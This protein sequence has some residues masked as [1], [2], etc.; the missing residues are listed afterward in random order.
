MKCKGHPHHHIKTG[1]A[2]KTHAHFVVR[3][4][5]IFWN[6]GRW[7]P[8]AAD[9]S[10]RR[11]ASLLASQ[12][13]TQVIAYRIHKAK[14]KFESSSSPPLQTPSLLHF[15]LFYIQYHRIKGKTHTALF[16]PMLSV[17]YGQ[18]EFSFHADYNFV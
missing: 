15:P 1:D 9:N 6:C 5:I 4:I 17:S 12:A 13:G 11:D 8:D 3:Y 16:Y 14:R 7:K 18:I 2:I 10:Q